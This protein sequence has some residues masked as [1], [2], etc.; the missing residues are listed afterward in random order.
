MRVL[1]SGVPRGVGVSTPPP[2]PHSEV[3]TKLSLIPISVDNTSVT[4]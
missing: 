2:P 4:T 3:L 1:S